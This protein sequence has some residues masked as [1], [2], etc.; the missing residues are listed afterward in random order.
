MFTNR[1]GNSAKATSETAEETTGCPTR[2]TQLQDDT[3]YQ[4]LFSGIHATASPRRRALAEFRHLRIQWCGRRLFELR[5][6]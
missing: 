1:K 2:L 6:G 3:R 4:I 5:A